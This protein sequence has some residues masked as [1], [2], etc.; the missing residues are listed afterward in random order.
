[1][2]CLAQQASASRLA[3]GLITIANGNHLSDLITT[4]NRPQTTLDLIKYCRAKGKFRYL[5]DT[6][7]I[8]I[9]KASPDLF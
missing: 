5:I 4:S 9:P 8:C 3:N 6:L 1:M 2:F 7:A